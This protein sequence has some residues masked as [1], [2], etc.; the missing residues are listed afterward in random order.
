VQPVAAE[1]KQ[2]PEQLHPA[3]NLAEAPSEVQPAEMELEQLFENL[4]SA[5]NLT[6]M[7]GEIQPAAAKPEFPHEPLPSR[8]GRSEAPTEILPVAAEPKPPSERPSPLDAL[9][10]WIEVAS[11]PHAREPKQPSEQ[12]SPP[13]RLPSWAE[14]SDSILEAES[15]PPSEPPH[16]A[17]SK[18]EIPSGKISP[19]IMEPEELHDLTA[20]PVETS[21]DATSSF[22]MGLEQPP[23]QYIRS[24]I[25]RVET[26][27][28]VALPPPTVEDRKT[29]PPLLDRVIR[30]SL[31]V[32]VVIAVITALMFLFPQLADLWTRFFPAR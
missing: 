13:A 15:E 18:F 10:N 16:P 25:N 22:V 24:P 31:F 21:T 14:P 4:Y 26:S 23:E 17:A 6:E 27:P 2:P 9:P 5:A 12:L 1:P 3:A 19:F 11:L 8:V 20:R 30:Y 32:V 28:V 7:P 29:I